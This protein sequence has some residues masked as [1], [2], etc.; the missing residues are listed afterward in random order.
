MSLGFTWTSENQIGQT[1][2]E[3]NS[4]TEPGYIVRKAV[5]T[6]VV[7]LGTFIYLPVLQVGVREPVRCSRQAMGET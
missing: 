2:T 3:T 1:N 4:G 6:F 5:Q 7:G